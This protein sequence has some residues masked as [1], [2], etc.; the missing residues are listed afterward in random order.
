MDA[1]F[2]KAVRAGLVLA[3]AGVA[4]AALA[5]GAGVGLLI[6]RTI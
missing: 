3:A 2:G 5:L 6:A 1:S 4:G